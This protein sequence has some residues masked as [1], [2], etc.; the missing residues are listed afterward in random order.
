MG[1][2]QTKSSLRRAPSFLPRGDTVITDVSHFIADYVPQNPTR[3]TQ[4]YKVQPEVVARGAYG[5]VRRAIHLPTNEMRTIK[6]IYKSESDSKEVNNILKEIQILKH[7]DH[8]NIIKIYE[9]F[10]DD[11]YLFVVAEFVKEGQIFEQIIDANQFSEKRAAV[12]FRQI[13]SAVNYLHSNFIVHRDL[14]SEN[15]VLDGDTIK[16][17]EFYCAREF[18]SDQKMKGVYGTSYYMA[19]EVIDHAYNEKCDI[20]SCGV[21]LYIMLGGLPPFDGD[22]DDE[23]MLN[24][25]KGQFTFDL[26]E[27]EHISDYAKKFIQR[28]LTYN[29]QQ[30]ISAAEALEDG[31]FR[32][33]LGENEILLNPAVFQN[34]KN[35]SVKNKLQEALYYFMVNNMATKEEKKELMET[36]QTL[37]TNQD[38]VLSKE[39]LTAGL[40]KINKFINEEE[41]DQIMARIDSN[42]DQ[43]INYT[44]FVAAAIDKR[45]LLTEDRIKACFRIFDKDGSGKITTAELKQMFQGKNVV[46]EK[47]W[48][49][50]IREVDQNGDGE[51]E[52][53]EFKEVLVKL[54]E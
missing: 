24:I 7:L 32:K 5:E 17:V 51:I 30:R 46:D 36:F 40:K 50:L 3:I 21:I 41:V 4:D 22:N 6:I 1:L 42:K 23:I 52:L 19:P 11:K 37:D 34:L 53:V 28:M 43:T 39:E 16:L 38:G 47:V 14:K 31:W 20:W 18:Q 2:C 49:D 25:Q 27:F 54:V 15:I 33:I 10:A 44:E 26:P 8:P 48:T 12:I 45:K 13:L 9:Y 35:F 29:P